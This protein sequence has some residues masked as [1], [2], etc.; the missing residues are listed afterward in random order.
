LKVKQEELISM[1][2]DQLLTFLNDLTKSEFFTNINYL[3]YLRGELEPAIR[4][5]M[6]MQ[7]E[8]NDI[9]NLKYGIKEF[10]FSNSMLQLLEL[11]YNEI[12]VNLANLIPK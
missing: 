2:F 3:K 7:K 11:E 10:K 1:K 6:E 4:N 12:K 5:T 9:V 8:I